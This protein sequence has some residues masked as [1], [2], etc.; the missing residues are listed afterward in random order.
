MS[1]HT[2]RHRNK[3][4][5]NETRIKESLKQKYQQSYHIRAG[6]HNNIN[7]PIIHVTG[8]RGKNKWTKNYL[9]NNG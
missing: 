9:K 7:Q 3:S 2:Y 4:N 8:V 5:Q 1:E 6:L